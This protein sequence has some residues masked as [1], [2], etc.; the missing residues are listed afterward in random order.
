[1]NLNFAAALLTLGADA[2]FR[3]ANGVRQPASRILADILPE[4][5]RATYHVEAGGM[6]VRSTMAGLVA[7]D[8]DY[9]PTGHIEVSTF[10]ENTAKIA[11]H[12]KLPEAALR[13]LQQMIAQLVA[14]SGGTL[15][16]TQTVVNEALNFFNL[17]IMQPQL[18]VSEWLRGQ[19]IALGALNWQFNKKGLVV[20]YGIPVGNVFPTR[21]LASNTAYAGTASAFWTDVRNIRRVLR[22]T[23]TRLIIAHP[24]TI[25]AAQ[26]NTANSM[27][28]T[29][30]TDASVT[31][32]K[33]IPNTADFTADANDTVTIVKYGLEGEILNPADPT[34]TLTMPF[35]PRGKLVGIGN[36]GP[37]GYRPGMGSQDNPATGV[38]LSNRIGYTHIAPTVESGGR[39][40]RWG[41][42][43]TP[44]FE[45][46][47]LHGRA[48]S[49]QIP[50]IESPDLIA[51]ATTEL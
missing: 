7:M 44:Q 4:E 14:Q 1:M 18:D 11:N 8:S 46:W 36:G 39:M 3:I 48:A 5:N 20:D 25:E 19:A 10:L 32:R 35:F 21:T 27:V 6:T 37:R 33:I 49:N 13:Q 29:A 26:Y 28:V 30:E 15:D 50:V 40:G 51:T 2:A 17:I 42:M 16:T 31:F 38:D 47:S 23:G 24:D 12:T 43:F 22:R 41:D 45:P 34:A 9:P